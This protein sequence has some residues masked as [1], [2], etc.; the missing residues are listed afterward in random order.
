MSAFIETI[1]NI[2]D[3]EDGAGTVYRLRPNPDC[4]DGFSAGAYLGWYD[5]GASPKDADENEIF[6]GPRAL[7]SLAEAFSKAADEVEG[8]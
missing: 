3:S 7:R 6:I 8:K 2:V 1:F 5:D 4:S